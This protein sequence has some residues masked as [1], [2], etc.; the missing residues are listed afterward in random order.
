MCNKQSGKVLR[1]SYLKCIG[2]VVR[3]NFYDGRT[4]GRLGGEKNKESVRF[5]IVCIERFS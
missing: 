2:G 4:D 3:P 5:I 1:N